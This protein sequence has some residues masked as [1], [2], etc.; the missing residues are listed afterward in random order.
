MGDA[1]TSRTAGFAASRLSACPA[2]ASATGN[3][4]VE[5]A[6]ARNTISASALRWMNTSPALCEPVT[7]ACWARSLCGVGCEGNVTLAGALVSAAR[8]TAGAAWVAC[9]G[10]ASGSCDDGAAGARKVKSTGASVS[11]AGDTDERW[12]TGDEPDA[13][14]VA[15]GGV[16]VDGIDEADDVEAAGVAARTG[17]ASASLSETSSAGARC[18][19]G[20]TSPATGKSGASAAGASNGFTA[21]R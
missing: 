12:I 11:V 5:T 3:T 13:S 19:S 10:G 1:F 20:I 15:P 14:G 8:C 18:T 6:G 4:G 2:G 16:E 9:A 21:M 17:D 7:A